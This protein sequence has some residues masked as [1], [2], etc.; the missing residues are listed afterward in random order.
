M[1]MSTMGH[2]LSSVGDY[3]AAVDYY[4]RSL[5]L[6]ETHV[7]PNHPTLGFTAASLAQAH[8]ALGDYDQAAEL[9]RRALAILENAFGP[10]DPQLGVALNNLAYSL[11]GLEQF[12][13]ARSM[14]ERSIEIV[15]RSWGPDHPQVA[16][17][18]LNLSSLEKQAG[19]FQAALDASRRA[20][21]ILTAAFGTDH[22]LYAY[23]ANNTGVFLMETGQA[24]QGVVHLEKALTIRLES[25]ADPVLIAVTRF[26]LGRARWEAG[27]RELG[28]RDVVEAEKELVAA[29]ELAEEDLEATREWLAK[30]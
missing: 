20:G 30:H 7:G 26:N 28:R 4:Q 9:S 18:L 5:D 12:G 25:G 2:A 10:D 1:A 3:T 8:A 14:H 17:S 16:I 15:S 24:A 29:G 21:E 6:K 27:L 19:D 22:P 13:E 11:E 23:A